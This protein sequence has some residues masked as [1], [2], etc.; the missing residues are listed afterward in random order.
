MAIPVA[1]HT[2]VAEG[3]RN[4]NCRPSFPPIAY[5]TVTAAIVARR[6]SPE[7]RTGVSLE[8]GGSRARTGRLPRSVY[9]D[10]AEGE[11]TDI[12][13]SRAQARVETAG[14]THVCAQAQ[15]KPEGG[16]AVKGEEG[17]WLHVGDDADR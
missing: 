9:P 10:C 5:T 11:S 4:A 1:G 17:R 16:P 8:A 6:R 2:G 12:P 7:R 15:G 3:C 14:E 13:Q